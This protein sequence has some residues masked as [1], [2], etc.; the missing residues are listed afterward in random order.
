[1][2]AITL[3][4]LFLAWIL[5]Y[6]PELWYRKRKLVLLS[7]ILLVTALVYKLTGG[8]L[9]LPYFVPGMGASVLIAVLLGS[10]PATILTSSSP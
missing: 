6:R 10:G 1:M 2:L 4:T 7:L 9:T 3:V 5:R 8:R